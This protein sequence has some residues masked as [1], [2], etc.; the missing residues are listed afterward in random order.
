M[1]VKL[2]GIKHV[3]INSEYIKLDSL[4]KLACIAST[5]GEAKVLILNGDVFVGGERCLLRGK[6][7][8]HGDVVRCGADV[9]VVKKSI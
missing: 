8:R 3:S 1:T 6:K 2:H 4:L 5:G 9:L 7:I